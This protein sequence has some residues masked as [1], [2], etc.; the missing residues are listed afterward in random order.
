MSF[1]CEKHEDHR[2]PKRLDSHSDLPVLREPGAYAD[3]VFRPEVSDF[4]RLWPKLQ[5]QWKVA[6][7]FAA[8]VLLVVGIGTFLTKPS[9]EPVAQLEIDPQGAELFNTPSTASDT[10]SDQYLGTAARKLQGDELAITVIR[11]LHLDQAPEFNAPPTF[12]EG[13]IA[14][15]RGW[16][17]APV[18][19]DPS[20]VKDTDSVIQLTHAE[21]QAL[22]RFRRQLKVGR[23]ST[24][25]LIT[26]SYSSGDP[27]VAA[28]VTN[29]LLTTFIEMTYSQRQA[30]ITQRSTW[31]EAQLNDVRKNLAASNRALADFQKQTGIADV[32]G[33]KNTVSEQMAE[34]GRQETLADSERIQLQSLF[35]SVTNPDAVADVQKNVVIQ[36]LSKKLAD[37]QV[38]LKKAE[39]IYGENH[40][41]VKKLENESAELQRQL[42]SQTDAIMRQLRTNYAAA[43]SR[44]RAIAA[45]VKVASGQL[46][47]VARYNELKKDVETNTTLANDLYRRIKEAGIA[48]GARATDMS[49]VGQARVLDRPSH[50]NWRLN[51]IAGMFAGV[52]GGIL[53]GFVRESLDSRIHAIEDLR[54]IAIASSVS[55]IP[56]FGS[57]LSF[58]E[59]GL[60]RKKWDTGG[61]EMYL[62]TRPNSPEAEALRGLGS[63]VMLAR[64]EKSLR[65]IL[66]TS[67]LPREG[68]S[69]LAVNF[70]SALSRHGKTCLIDADLRAPKLGRAFDIPNGAGLSDLLTGQPSIRLNSVSGL[71]NLMV[72]T[73]GKA[74]TESTPSELLSSDSMR[75]ILDALRAKFDSV[76]IDAP[77]LLLFAEARV[78][79]TLVDGIIMVCRY[80]VTTRSDLAQSEAVL[81]TVNAAP[82]IEVV[83]NGAQIK[84]GDYPYY[85]YGKNSSSAA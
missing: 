17:G 56:E 16:Q 81:K 68:K 41:T 10:G 70:A 54:G 20:R 6:A 61:P 49:I 4:S 34:L 84:T 5:K 40:P 69:T 59:R 74:E 75:K 13:V 58:R 12:L 71:P 1:N 44:K 7:L 52:L 76:V 85:R 83:M 53:I 48:A 33:A 50:P 11:K 9:Y 8:T 22:A 19:E 35:Q 28:N 46:G 82:V 15:I 55:L 25:R 30:A 3:T 67:S 37:T 42:N 78:L 62:Q 80:G 2:H 77:P 47:R 66:V 24:S 79:A 45:E 65:V 29:T 27:V 18:E 64:A 51:L 31:L 43:Q 60:I 57:D 73:A 38:E 26:V 63:C 21:N 14:Q 23:D 36:E 32:D 39:V 72:L